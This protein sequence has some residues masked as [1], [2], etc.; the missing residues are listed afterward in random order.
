MND[1]VHEYCLFLEGVKGKIIQDHRHS[2]THMDELLVIWD[3]AQLGLSS[4]KR[5]VSLNPIN[6]SPSGF[7]SIRGNILENF[8]EIFLCW[9]Q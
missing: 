2:V 9:A 7:R 6:G 3:S 8:R 1:S 5:K 4:K